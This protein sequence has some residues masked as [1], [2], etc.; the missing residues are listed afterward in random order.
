M[1]FELAEEVG[2]DFPAGA[3]DRGR[4]PR[5]LESGILVWTS[6]SCG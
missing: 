2:R 4:S 6:G 1:E 5:L 3:Q